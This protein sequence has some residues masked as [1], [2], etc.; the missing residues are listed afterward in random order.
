M[1]LTER[2]LHSSRLARF[3]DTF[4]VSRLISA[5]DLVF[6]H[7]E[8]SSS[9]NSHFESFGHPS[10]PEILPLLASL[11]WKE[12]EWNTPCLRVKSGGHCEFSSD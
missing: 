8:T 4:P 6:K 1:Q 7:V 12:L 10:V 9:E 2:N 5:C 11:C 3:S